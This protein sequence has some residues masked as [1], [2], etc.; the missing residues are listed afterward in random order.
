[1]HEPAELLAS[2]NLEREVQRDS[3]RRSRRSSLEE[4]FFV[5]HMDEVE[6]QQIF[7]MSQSRSIETEAVS[8]TSGTR[9]HM[10]EL[11]NSKRHA[12]AAAAAAAYLL[13]MM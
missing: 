13:L 5:Y 1:M 6:V 2:G 12:A 4:K 3:A 11:N 7:A 9:M 10:T 8:A